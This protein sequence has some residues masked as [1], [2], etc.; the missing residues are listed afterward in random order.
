MA[1][2][3]KFN[4]ISFQ[5]S[6]HLSGRLAPSAHTLT[7][8]MEP[9]ILFCFRLAAVNCF[10]TLSIFLATGFLF[11]IELDTRRERYSLTSPNPCQPTTTRTQQRAALFINTNCLSYACNMKAARNS[12]QSHT[13]VQT[14]LP[15][16]LHM[17]T[18]YCSLY[19]RSIF[20]FSTQAHEGGWLLSLENGPMF[21][22]GLDVSQQQG[23][24]SLGVNKTC[25]IDFLTIGLSCARTQANCVPPPPP[26]VGIK[27]AINVE[28]QREGN[29]MKLKKSAKAVNGSGRAQCLMSTGFSQ[30]CL[31]DMCTRSRK[32][33]SCRRL[34]S[35][36]I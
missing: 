20:Q 6:H 23:P 25:H 19:S 17:V 30:M 22:T 29:K 4:S 10:C 21:R 34:L 28:S 15:S 35:R 3:A 26:C 24:P 13:K 11:S 2:C 1:K 32:E 12:V 27:L 33:D 31:Y 16:S 18:G 8:R 36:I 9:I 5:P 14:R 7:T